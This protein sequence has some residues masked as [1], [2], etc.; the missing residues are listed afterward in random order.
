MAEKHEEHEGPIHQAGWVFY[1]TVAVCYAVLGLV[2]FAK[3]S[4]ET[5][6]FGDIIQVFAIQAGVLAVFIGVFGGLLYL[7]NKL[8]GAT[9]GKE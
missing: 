1:L 4:A 6:E 7:A 3:W 8:T 5:I 2:M 9:A